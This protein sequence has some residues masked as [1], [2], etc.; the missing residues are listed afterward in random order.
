MKI[1]IFDIESTPLLGYA[2][3]TWKTDIIR[4]EQEWQMICFAYKWYGSKKGPTFVRPPLDE[5][6]D[7]E[8]MVK[9]LW[10]LFDEADILIGHNVDKFDKKKTNALFLRH[11]LLPP[12]PTRTIDTL[13]VSRKNFANASNSLNN[14]GKLLNIGEKTSGP[15]YMKLFDGCM[16]KNDERVWRAMKKYNIQDV[17][18]TEKLYRRLLPWITNHPIDLDNP[19]GCTNCGGTN[20]IKRGFRETRSFRYQRYRCD[21]CGSWMSGRN[22]I[23]L[24]GKPEY[25]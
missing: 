3:G 2:W 18:L 19:S 9:T 10:K 14:L 25:V 7:D 22:H 24:G 5:P 15:G 23:D 17:S 21:D 13:K 4:V 11:G 12:S 8:A 20:L 16:L 1:L 6:W